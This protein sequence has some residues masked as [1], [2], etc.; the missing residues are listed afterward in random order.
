MISFKKIL[1][2]AESR[3]LSDSE[4]ESHYNIR[5]I[6]YHL[7]YN[8]LN[9]ILSSLKNGIKLIIRYEFKQ[10]KIGHYVCIFIHHNT[11]YF[12][13]SLGYYPDYEVQD[14]DNNNMITLIIDR[15]RQ[16]SYEY[17]Q[18]I[19]KH[20]DIDNNTNTCGRHCIVRLIYN[21]LDNSQYNLFI[22][23]LSHYNP[24]ETV[25]LLTLFSNINFYL[26][27]K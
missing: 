21:E 6:P 17:S 1:E 2:N 8:M 3:P 26:K 11:I 19:Y 5:I 22:N 18:N 20:Q 13:D 16:E 12:Y 7:I 24:D 10:Q 25:T 15:L 23:S 4:I 27:S 9:D 14:Q